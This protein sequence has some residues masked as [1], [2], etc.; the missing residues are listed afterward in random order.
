[1]SYK[2]GARK[3]E[4]AAFAAA[5]AALSLPPASCAFIDD[6]GVSFTRFNLISHRFDFGLICHSASAMCVIAYCMHNLTGC[7]SGINLKAARNLGFATVKML[8]K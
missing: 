6:L 8:P 4:P 5:A 3:P 2:I 7:S 1:M